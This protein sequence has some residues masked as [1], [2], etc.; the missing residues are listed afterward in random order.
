MWRLGPL[1]AAWARQDLQVAALRGGATLQK[2]AGG[3]NEEQE[4]D[5][6]LIE[7]IG[8]VPM[9]W[10]TKAWRA[11]VKGGERAKQCGR[12]AGNVTAA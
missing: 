9:P 6:G 11:R 7:T 2:S 4:Q 12:R 5:S 3:G 10:H 1:A 8:G